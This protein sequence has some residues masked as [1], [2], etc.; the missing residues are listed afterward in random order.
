MKNA[1]EALAGKWGIAVG[2][3]LLY[4]VIV[5]SLNYVFP[6]GLIFG[7]P[8]VVG[9][10]IFTLALYRKEEATIEQLFE[11]FKNFANSV[12]AYLLM[13]LYVFLWTLLLIIPGIIASLNYSQIMFILA[14]D[15]N[16]KGSEALK[17]SKEMMK[18][19]RWKLVCLSFRFF[20]WLL[21]SILTL[22]VG[23]LWL[24]PYMQVSYAGFYEDIKKASFK[25]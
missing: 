6:L 20:G 11:G 21:L 12:V 13:T 3:S 23:L 9:L 16:I 25:K 4:S 17:K 22:G 1:R 24:I 19:N 5:G 15:K 10:A 2:G 14:E 8:M 7:G 18:G